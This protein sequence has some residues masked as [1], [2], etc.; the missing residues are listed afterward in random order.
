ML[1]QALSDAC[2][3]LTLGKQTTSGPVWAPLVLASLISTLAEQDHLDQAQAIASAAI[4]RSNAVV[5]RVALGLPPAG[6]CSSAESSDPRPTWHSRSGPTN[7]LP[8]TNGNTTYGL[9]RDGEVWENLGATLPAGVV[10]SALCS[11]SGRYVYIGSGWRTVSARPDRSGPNHDP[12]AS[13]EARHGL[14][15]NSPGTAFV[16]RFVIQTEEPGERLIFAARSDRLLRLMEPDPVDPSNPAIFRQIE[17]LP[18][19]LSYVHGVDTDWT[20]NPK[21]LY[22]AYQTGVWSGTGLPWVYGCSAD[23]HNVDP[24]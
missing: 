5:Y 10:C 20:V 17:E 3:A 19:N 18:Y 4:D 22:V 21:R 12:A 14:W 24:A 7:V 6:Y 8:S 15:S 2:L 11:G 16:T 23:G 9:N 13:R 1:D